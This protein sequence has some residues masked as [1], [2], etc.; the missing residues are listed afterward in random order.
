MPEHFPEFFPSDRSSSA[1]R[2]AAGPAEDAGMG[3]RLFLRAGLL[4]AGGALA[5]CELVDQRTFNPRASRPP[6]VIYTPAPVIPP[7]PPLIEL[8]AGTPR[9]EWSGPVR[10]VVRQAL[11]RKPNILFLVEAVA[12]PQQDGTATQALLSR[13]V[14]TDGQSIADEIVAAGASPSQVEMSAMPDSTV[15]GP[16]I[17]VYVR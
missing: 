6:R 3:R 15:T 1:R 4:G 17:R 2:E 13:L 14:G 10:S 8:V 12:P 7:V 16:R 11:D 9:A 5:G